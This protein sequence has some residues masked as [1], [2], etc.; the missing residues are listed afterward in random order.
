VI[1]VVITKLILNTDEGATIENNDSKSELLDINNSTNTEKDDKS[2]SLKVP[3]LSSSVMEKNLTS[4]I[5]TPLTSHEAKKDVKE[6]KT[7]STPKKNT[8]DSKNNT[9]KKVHTPAKKVPS[10]NSTPK[11][12]YIDKVVAK[13]NTR[14]SSKK[15]SSFLGGKR[16]D[17]SNS[18]Y[19][20]V[21]TYRDTSSV[22][23]KIKKNNFNYGLI[24]VE[25][26]NT[27]TRV[28][29]GPFYSRD[30][31]HTQLAK[32]KANILTGAYITKAK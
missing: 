21:G 14:I 3:V 15:S 26:D 6:I 19:I 18:Y 27:L 9:P 31:A 32:V 28:L 2:T 29:V 25:N 1:S 4:V 22:L 24:K 11:K 23:R 20:K 7:Y 30:Q 8:L 16:K 5:K 17:I 12:E 13:K 10:V